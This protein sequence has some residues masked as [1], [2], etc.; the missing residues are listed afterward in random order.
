M[1]ALLARFVV[2]LQVLRNLPHFPCREKFACR[3][4]D[5]GKSIA[6]SY[7]F[8]VLPSSRM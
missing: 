6:V 4:N 2:F 5:Q 7:L 8:A 3:E 1:T